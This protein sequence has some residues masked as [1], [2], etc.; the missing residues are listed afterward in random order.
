MGLDAQ[1]YAR[2]LR[3]HLPPGRLW[4]KLLDSIIEAVLLGF[5]DEFVRVDERGQLLFYEADPRTAT[6]LLP[7]FEEEYGFEA[8]G[9]LAQRRARVYARDLAQPGVRPADFQEALAPLLGQAAV[10]VVVIETSSTLAASFGHPEEI[11]RFFIYRD[12]AEPGSYDL[13]A[14]QDLV[15]DMAHS[16]TRGH[17][18]ESINFLCEDEFSLCDRD[19]LGA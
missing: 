5:A 18:I 17:V 8:E 15:D 6:E 11:Y 1:G 3:Q 9:T 10:D 2:S 12:P 7:E 4:S 14:A 13:A 19:L 16:H